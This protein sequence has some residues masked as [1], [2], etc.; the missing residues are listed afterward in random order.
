AERVSYGRSRRLTPASPIRDGASAGRS[1][2]HAAPFGYRPA[3][4]VLPRNG[5]G[6]RSRLGQVRTAGP[7]VDSPRESSLFRPLVLARARVGMAFFGAA[8]MAPR[9]PDARSRCRFVGNAGAPPGSSPP[10]DTSLPGLDPPRGVGD[11]ALR[12]RG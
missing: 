6:G 2:Q 4:P 11:R 3:A 9:L 1:G 10:S 5:S 8:G 12:P 7:P